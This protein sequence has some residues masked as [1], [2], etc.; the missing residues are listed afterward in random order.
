[1][2]G[3]DSITPRN[4][5]YDYNDATIEPDAR[6]RDAQAVNELRVTGTQNSFATFKYDESGNL[7]ERSIPVGTAMSLVWDGDDQLVRV[8]GAGAAT[9]PARLGG[10]R[11]Q[12]QPTE[13]M[14]SRVCAR[15]CLHRTRSAR[16]V[17]VEALT[18]YSSKELH[19]AR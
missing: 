19:P 12:H 17:L 13:T 5:E 18:Y 10:E 8:S 14:R 6:R 7:V 11:W 16:S 15:P 1:V 9:A 3:P 2:T 4:V